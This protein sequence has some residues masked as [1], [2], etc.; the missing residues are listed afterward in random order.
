[1][2]VSIVPLN[3][4]A[5]KNLKLK[6]TADFDF[7]AKQHMIPLVVQE[8]IQASTNFPVVFVKDA[9]KEGAYRAVA[10]TATTPEQNSYVRDNTWLATYTPMHVA[11]HPFVLANDGSKE[12]SMM[13]CIAESSPR[14]SDTEGNA[15][16]TAE[17]EQSEV[18][19]NITK[20][21]GDLMQFD[22]MT[23]TFIAKLVELDLLEESTLN[24][25]S[26]DGQERRIGGINVVNAEKLAKLDD[27]V[28]VELFKN[29]MM[30]AIH[31]H[32]ASLSQVNRILQLQTQA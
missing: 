14:L 27:A 30:A 28:V 20:F 2:A 5:H 17:G 19:Q 25:R 4:E 23:E 9:N 7:L 3:R 32:M 13:I 31:A 29:G 24:L 15:L 6:N 21:L 22:A 26:A 10:I 18:M 8:F 12:D 16:F 11:R 1:M